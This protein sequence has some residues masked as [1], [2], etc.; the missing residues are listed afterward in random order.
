[1]PG[2]E[3]MLFNPWTVGI[4]VALGG[5][6]AGI[7][8]NQRNQQ[9]RQFDKAIDAESMYRSQL[10]QD[11]ANLRRDTFTGMTDALV[12]S[13]T[14]RN[15]NMSQLMKQAYDNTSAIGR[16][17]MR[18]YDKSIADSTR[19]Q[20]QLETQKPGKYGVG[21]FFTDFIGGGVKG[22][23]MGESFM[24]NAQAKEQAG[25]LGKE[26]LAGMKAWRNAIDLSSNLSNKL[27]REDEWNKSMKTNTL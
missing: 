2:E 6:N 17:G 8:A 18:E 19:M 27:L 21:D 15:P 14:T 5:L 26:Q 24:A 4:G 16:Q 22:Y 10:Q 12:S 13:A 1:M 11:K 20:Q 23:Q 25:I 9:R 7:S 3:S